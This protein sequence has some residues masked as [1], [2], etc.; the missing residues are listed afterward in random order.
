[1]LAKEKIYRLGAYMDQ[2]G[3]A[4]KKITLTSKKANAVIYT[5]YYQKF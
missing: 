1:M 3:N 2:P 5:T 4:R